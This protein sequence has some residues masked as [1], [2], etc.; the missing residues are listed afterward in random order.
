MEYAD[1]IHRKY[2]TDY[3]QWMPDEKV[4]VDDLVTVLARL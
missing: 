3:A 2:F 1:L 4:L